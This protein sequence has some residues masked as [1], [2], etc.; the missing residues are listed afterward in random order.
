[1]CV[2]AWCNNKPIWNNYCRKH[3]DEIRKY[4][5]ITNN[6][7]RGKRNDY[8]ICNN[9]AELIILD[10]EGLE[11]VRTKIDIEDVDKL[12][13][14]SFRYDKGHYIKGVT[15]N[16]NIYLHRIVMDY[17]GNLEIDHINRNKL[18][19]RKCN[20]RIVDRVMNANNIERKKTC[21]ISKTKR[22]LKKPYQLKIKKKYI[23]YYKTLEEAINARNNLVS[24]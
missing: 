17:N 9:Y 15:N 13:M 14:Y 2:I 22:K 24:S 8:I 6:R 16:K 11:I 23:G 7:P 5:K 3:Y 20:L 1:M 21:G 19:N 18:D 12:K 4:G 10:K